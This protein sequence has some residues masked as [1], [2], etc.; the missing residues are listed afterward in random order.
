MMFRVRSCLVALLAVAA[1]AGQLAAQATGTVSGRIINADNQLPMARVAVSLA[2][3]AVQTSTDGRF[4]FI[5]V[6]AGEHVLRARML[7]YRE[8]IDT[9]TVVAGRTTDVQLAMQAA[10]VQ[11]ETIVATGYGESEKRDLTGVV[12]EVT[13]E[14]FNTG[15]VVSPEELIRGKV[16]GVQ[17]TEQNG[18]EPGGGMSIRIRGGTSI[19]SSNEPLYVIDG[20]IIPP[21]GG[22]SAGRNPLNFLNPNDIQSFTVLKDASSTAI[23]GSQGANGVVLITTRGGKGVSDVGWAMSYTGTLSGSS[24]VANPDI[25]NAAEFRAAVEDQAPSQLVYLGEAS[26]DWNKEVQRSGFGQEHTVV[27]GARGDKSSFRAS[28]GYLN[29]QGVVRSTSNER[30][31]LNLA[32]NQLL[33]NDN[34]SIQANVMGAR[35]EDEFTGGAVLGSANNFAPTQPVLDS[36]SPYGGYF[37]WDNTLAGTNPVG[38]M[39]LSLDRGI[40]YRS[41]GNITGEYAFPFLE[42]L[43]VTGRVGYVVTNAQTQRFFASI[44]KNQVNRGLN[45]QV[46]R[47]TP[48]ET[49]TLFDGFL[50]YARS[51]LNHALTFTGGY[52]FTQRRQDTP[53]LLAQ[54]LA[55]DFLGPD[56]IPT[57]QLYQTTLTVDESK[58]GSYFARANYAFKDRYLLTATIRTDGSSKFG[59]GNQWGTF[60]SAAIAWRI[61]EEDFLGDAFSDLKLR[62]SWG[63]NGNSAFNSYQQ[64]KSYQYSDAQSQVQFGNEYFSTIR[65]SAADPNIKWE[66]TA[67]WNLGL[68]YGLWNNRL[69]GALEFYTK[70]TQ[71][72]IFTVLVPSG[73]NLSNV[74]TTNVG[75]MNNKG[76]ELTLNALLAD[77][78]DGGIGWDAS[79][80]LAYNKNKLVVID[81]FAGGA[82]RILSG[83]AISGGVG[84]YIQVLEPG[85]PV[86]SFFVYEHILDADGKPIWEDTN[87]DGTIN[88]QDI[89]VDQLTECDDAGVCTA[90]GVVNQ[91]DRRAFHKP[92]P[93]W[94][95]GFTSAM[96]YGSFDLAF[97][98]LAQLGNYVYNNVASNSGFYNTLTNSARPNNL[99]RSVL[100]NGFVTPQYFSDVYVENASFL[101]MDNIQ[102]GYRL[103]PSLNNMRVFAGVQN[104]FTI[105]GYSGVDPTASLNGIDNNRYPRTRTFSA[106]VNIG[107]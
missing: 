82:E 103:G 102:L 33:L 28:L 35:S 24:V 8:V 73:V 70:N 40:T 42:G 60:P 18:G 64:Y 22:L 98:L 76:F 91:D 54:D 104:V 34:L 39:N 49:S 52:A 92:S 57:A 93:D 66:E 83:D 72:L 101:R 107:F 16:A 4:M 5:D 58:L 86:N 53:F 55:S 77:A 36:L 63:K 94:L 59:P 26:T 46:S 30:L 84:S 27:V 67:S 69:S 89:Y 13:T 48:S 80:N 51:S 81:P 9:I 12:T 25:L 31:T 19:T 99:H 85:R 105:T 17:V 50:T 88:E 43:S 68:D 3:R 1:L 23:Y 78:A 106:G 44:Q 32:F 62:L 7:G 21:G 11:L 71:D 45:G 96:R 29:Q 2:S 75:E 14:Q 74:V 90:D 100:E 41:L 87:E 61:S 38:A 47:W 37:E 56:G 15:R 6:P 65:P 95:M 10:A 20:V 79:F 97:T